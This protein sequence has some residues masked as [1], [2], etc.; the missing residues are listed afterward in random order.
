MDSSSVIDSSSSTTSTRTG[1]PSGLS[2]SVRPWGEV[3]VMAPTM[4]GPP[5]STLSDICDFP[6][7]RTGGTQGTPGESH[8]RLFDG[9][10]EAPA[11]QSDGSR[12]RPLEL[13]PL[14][15][16]PLLVH[17][18]RRRPEEDLGANRAVGDVE[19][20]QPV[21]PVPQPD[22]T[23]EAVVEPPPHPLTGLEPHARTP[24]RPGRH[25][26]HRSHPGK[27]PQPPVRLTE[28][29]V[30]SSEVVALVVVRHEV[31][32]LVHPDRVDERI[33]VA[34]HRGRRQ[35]EADGSRVSPG[36]GLAATGPLRPRRPYPLHGDVH[37]RPSPS[38][39]QPVLNPRYLL[40]L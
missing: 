36:R 2:S 38:S 40:E 4:S 11:R 15:D 3:V 26:E 18:D 23:A 39:E 37:P 13:R 25:P 32:P 17:M 28:L 9:T 1:L 16:R 6:E 35:H 12:L 8:V 30:D 14:P 7:K 10:D 22:G 19:G 5:E 27:D 21:R 20:V 34:P 24:P 29:D 31:V 33:P